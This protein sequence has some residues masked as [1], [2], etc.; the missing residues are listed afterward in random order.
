MIRLISSLTFCMLVFA[1]N[2]C[3]SQANGP[4]ASTNLPSSF[5]PPWP[6]Y[7]PKVP[8]EATNWGVGVR[9][10]QLLLYPTNT[11][12]E[13]GSSITMLAVI[14]NTSTNSIQVIEKDA[15]SD[16]ELLLTNV[17]GKVYDLTP[18]LRGRRLSMEIK[19]GAQLALNIPV[20]FRSDVEPG[21]THFEQLASASS[22]T[23]DLPLSPTC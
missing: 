2:F 9:G 8:Q 4:L 3:I 1:A 15:E 6:E 14:T 11:V 22:K 21:D 5:A 10:V 16:F 20:T 17:A 19:G 23:R 13:S 12:I 7:Q 18:V